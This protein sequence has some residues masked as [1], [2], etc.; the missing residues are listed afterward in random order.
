MFLIGG[1]AVLWRSK[2]LQG[3]A[4]TTT[5][6]E[7][8]SLSDT[9][10]EAV[11]LRQLMEELGQDASAIVL[12]CDNQGA[13]K[14]SLQ[15]SKLSFRTKHV[16]VAWHFVREAI[17][18]GEVDVEFVPS[19]EQCADILTKA[20]EGC[21]FRRLRQRLGLQPRD[22]SIVVDESKAHNSL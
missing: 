4:T 11:W 10:K 1:G 21:Q 22:S 15:N 9:A 16:R 19:K 14:V 13:L 17:R 12:R 2:K 7:Y 3:I 5:V 6:A 18:D 8:K 20:V